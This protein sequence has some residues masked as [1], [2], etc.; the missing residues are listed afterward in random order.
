MLEA[1]IA[2]PKTSTKH[3]NRLNHPMGP[4][5]LVDS[6]LDVRLRFSNIPSNPRRKVPAQSLLRQYVQEDGLAARPGRRLRL[7]ATKAAE[8]KI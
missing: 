7:H 6:S 1:G 3:L 8:K 2:T 4:F 5:E